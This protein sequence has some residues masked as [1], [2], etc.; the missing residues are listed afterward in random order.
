M[1]VELEESETYDVDNFT[2]ALRIKSF[3]N[4]RSQSR[5]VPR[6]LI[7]RREKCLKKKKNCKKLFVRSV[8][9]VSK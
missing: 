3:G 5:Y 9:R 2:F 4:T 6:K 8:F 1:H 7:D